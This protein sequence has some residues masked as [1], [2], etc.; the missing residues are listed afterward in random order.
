MSNKGEIMK[1]EEKNWSKTLLVT[2]GHLETICGAID[3]TVLSYGIGSRTS[4]HDAEYVANKMIS[5]IERKKFLINIKVLV[6]KILSNIG[7][8]YARVLTLKYI[9]RIDS[10]LASQTM[11][12][13]SRTY[14]RKI[15]MGI[16]CFWG[17]LE[18][19]GYNEEILSNLFKDEKWIMEIYNS[20][21]KKDTS[22]MEIESMS[23]I[24]IA[25]KS[26]KQ[27]SYL[28]A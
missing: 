16:E 19:M 25:L 9:D 24:G 8:T 15:N 27:K 7:S 21:E 10:A 1:T 12:I 22:D 6:D 17:Q 2:Y 5:L 13:S 3:K 18:K 20:Y 11:K 26:F 4:F 23:L 28:V 14:F